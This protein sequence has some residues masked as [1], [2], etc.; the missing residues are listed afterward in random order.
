[1]YF[2]E[3]R[4]SIGYLAFKVIISIYLVVAYVLSHFQFY[5]KKPDDYKCN[6]YN[7]KIPSVNNYTKEEEAKQE[8]IKHLCDLESAWP[9]YWLYLTSWS[10]NIFTLCIFLDTSLV[11]YRYIDEKKKVENDRILDVFTAQKI[12]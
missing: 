1:M 5:W 2:S 12:Q 8:E 11:I 6:E 7:V 4:V 10:F 9:Y 3:D